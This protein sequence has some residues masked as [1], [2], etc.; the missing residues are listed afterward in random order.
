MTLDEKL[1]HFYNAA[2][3]SATSQNI[4]IVDEYQKS[5]QQIYEDHKKDSLRKAEITYR[6]ESEKLLREK[7]RDLSAEAIKLK[8]KTSEKSAEL[9]DK[10]FKEVFD[11]LTEFMTTPEYFNL[12]CRQ[13][14]DILKFARDDDVT[15]YLNPTDLNLL[16]SLEAGTGAVLT[17]STRDFIGGTRAV[18]HDKNILID[19]SFLTKLEEVKNSLIL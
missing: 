15:I 11:R 7:N 16:D 4:Q 9:T 2:I 17:I 13:I 6:T 1:E 19:N 14:K 3:E 10:L 5:L 8:R 18:L 12:L